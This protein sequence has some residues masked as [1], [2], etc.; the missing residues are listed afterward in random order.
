[1]DNMQKMLAEA[2]ALLAEA[3]QKIEHVEAPEVLIDM[4]AI[5]D[6]RVRLEEQKSALRAKKKILYDS[7]VV[8]LLK[9]HAS[10]VKSEHNEGTVVRWEDSVRG[11][12][13]VVSESEVRWAGTTGGKPYHS[14]SEMLD[15]PMWEREKTSF[16]WKVCGGMHTWLEQYAERNL[17]QKPENLVADANALQEFIG[18]L[19][20][21]IRDV[22][23]KSAA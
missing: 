16:F 22:Q 12:D 5:T 21:T 2:E 19:Q 10:E 15:L 9:A 3:T 17:R 8:C 6:F 18:K 14:H 13:I 20:E 4:Q 1:M 11:T 7:L 23:Q